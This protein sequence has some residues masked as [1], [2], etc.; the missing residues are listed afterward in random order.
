M[1]DGFYHN[2]LLRLHTIIT[3]LKFDLEIKEKVHRLHRKQ[4]APFDYKYS[5]ICDIY[6]ILIRVLRVDVSP[7]QVNLKMRLAVNE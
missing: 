6:R 7:K 4:V 5:N 2:I 1:L 3:F